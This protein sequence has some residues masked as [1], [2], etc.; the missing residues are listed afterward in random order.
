MRDA[1]GCVR[2]AARVLLRSWWRSG[3]ERGRPIF[4]IRGLQRVC[5]TLGPWIPIQPALLPD[6][7]PLQTPRSNTLQRPKPTSA[8]STTARASSNALL[9]SPLTSP[10]T[11]SATFWSSPTC[12]HLEPRVRLYHAYAA[13]T[14]RLTRWPQVQNMGKAVMR[15]AK[16]SIKV[17]LP[18]PSMTGE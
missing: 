9:P 11:D 18:S 7:K 13:C 12:G 2:V 4:C 17:R 5:S 1:P 10:R 14:S 6:Y 8:P 15:T 16:N 3:K